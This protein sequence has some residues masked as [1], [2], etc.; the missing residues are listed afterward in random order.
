MQDTLERNETTRQVQAT[1][2]PRATRRAMQGRARSAVLAG[3]VLFVLAQAGLRAVIEEARPDLRD[4]TFEIKYRRYIEL[5]GQSSQ[6]PATMMF[7][8]SSMTVFGVNAEAVD[9]PCSALLGRPVVGYNLGV[10]GSGPFAQLVFLQRLLR[11]GARPDWVVVE[12][13]PKCFDEEDVFGELSRFPASMLNRADLD[14][15]ERYA[16]NPDLRNEW[17][18]SF[19]VPVHGHRLTIVHQTVPVFLTGNDQLEVWDDIDDHGWRRLE[20]PTPEHRRRVLDMVKQV[21]EPQ[22][23]R[24]Q[25]GRWRVRALQELTDLLAHERIPALLVV[26]PEGPLMR[27]FYPRESLAPLL[28]EFDQV[29][30]KRGF[31]L[32]QARAWLGE[33][34]FHDSLHLTEVGGQEFTERLLREAIL[35]WLEL[36]RNTNLAGALSGPSHE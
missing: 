29:S 36:N 19:L 6:P 4:P 8:G 3:V 16:K 22:L 13:A 28:R 34:K 32:V 5:K 31:P 1:A 25:V 23:A 7:L 21:N 15:V 27:S 30:Q 2:P 20:V 11:R 9:Q 10:A 17:W 14:T 24:Y 35:P 33:E 12:L 18:R 26:M